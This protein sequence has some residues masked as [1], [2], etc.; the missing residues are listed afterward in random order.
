MD[1]LLAGLGILAPDFVTSDILNELA[2]IEGV[3]GSGQDPG[4]ASRLHYP[5][6]YS[7]RGVNLVAA[8]REKAGRANPVRARLEAQQEGRFEP[9]PPAVPDRR[10]ANAA[11]VSNSS[12]E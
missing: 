9:I 11:L 10:S 2:E 6:F 12:T 4:I 8:L 3:T 7:V 1:L 5:L